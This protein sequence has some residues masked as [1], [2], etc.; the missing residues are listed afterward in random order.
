MF[1]LMK[2]RNCAATVEQKE[3]RRLHYCGTCKTLGSRYGAASRLLLNHDA[4]FLGELL[5]AL[6][7]NSASPNAAWARAYQSYNCFALPGE[8]DEMPLSLQFAAAANVLL[9]E[10]KVA[11]QI[12]DSRRRRWRVVRRLL[13]RPFRLASA[14]LAAWEFPLGELWPLLGEQDA[15]EATAQPTLDYLAE[16]TAQATALFFRHGAVLLQL[17]ADVQ[18]TLAQVGRAFG[19]LVYTLDALEDYAQDVQRDEFN[20]FRAVYGWREDKLSK[21]Q[22]T[23]A[24][25]EVRAVAREITTLLH[26][27]PLPAVLQ[28]SFAARVNGNLRAKLTRGLPVLARTQ[29]ACAPTRE[30]FGERWT[31]ARN[32]GRKLAQEHLKARSWVGYLKYPLVFAT[33]LL[34]GLVWPQQAA[35][36]RS[37]R[38]CL[39]F[40]FNLMFLGAFVSAVWAVPRNILMSD[41]TAEAVQQEA[42]K[43]S[44]EGGSS[45]SWCDSCDCCSDCGDCGCGGCGDS[46]HCN[47][48][49][50]CCDG[51]HGCGCNCGDCCDGCNCCDG[52]DCNC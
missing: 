11:D 24:E 45:D 50:N 14:H 39:N 2:A 1:G 29:H 38:E 41:P 42:A 12:N 4:V 20:A 36:A 5:T 46:C 43:K 27:L 16:P 48:C 52:C 35:Q 33:V 7:T 31:R 30:T 25:G 37:G 3:L 47:S 21:A 34:V 44:K 6:A 51:C 32:I 15:R 40:G 19:R 28:E 49:S 10:F 26:D 23:L 18:T 17:P 9:T 8:A 13:S 22:R